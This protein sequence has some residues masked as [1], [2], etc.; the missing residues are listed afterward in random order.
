LQESLEKN[1][2]RQSGRLEKLEV[3]LFFSSR[4]GCCHACDW[5]ERG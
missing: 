4:G 1:T 3:L 2:I 5:F